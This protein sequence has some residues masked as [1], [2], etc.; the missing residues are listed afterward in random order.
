MKSK[1]SLNIKVTKNIKSEYED[2][3]IILKSKS[4]CSHIINDI[5]LSGYQTSLDYEYL[6][7]NKFTH[8]VN[9]AAN[10]N[11]FTSQQFPGIAYLTM[12]IKDELGF[13]I[14]KESVSSVIEFIKN[15]EQ[16]SNR[17]VLIHCYEG[18]SRA[19]ALLISY[20][21]WKYNL[22]KD[23]AIKFVKEKRPCVDINLGFCV[24]LEKLSQIWIQKFPKFE[25][26]SE[27]M[28]IA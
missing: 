13:D 2:T 3:S 21:I 26:V 19:P 23:S 18:V 20:M 4:E 22:D 27:M 24:Q 5:Y 12:E 11:R 9:C 6:K 10:S 15:A 7:N 14:L 28:V 8:I 1:L 25:N 17:K 16:I